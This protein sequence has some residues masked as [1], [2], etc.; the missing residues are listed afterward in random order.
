[1]LAAA[2]PLVGVA[3]LLWYGA[4]LAAWFERAATWQALVAIIVAGAVLCGLALLPTH[5]LSLA[6]GFVL[7]G[8]AGTLVAWATI[9]L[10]ALFGYAIARPL[11][12]GDAAN[13][14]RSSPRWSPFAD[15]LLDRS[16][17]RTVYLI[18]LVRL[19]PLVPF[20][21]TNTGLAALR[22]SIAPFLLGAAA[23]LLPR[24]AAVAWFGAGLATLDWQSPRSPWLLIVGG[25]A[26]VVAL[27]AVG[28][29]ATRTL[30]RAAPRS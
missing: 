11:T 20:A 2:L 21:A 28:R 24:I 30:R 18:A 26:T 14:L 9:V 29:V 6:A 1:M 5:A 22:V 8:I 12:G 4:E 10:A 23:G 13:R 3:F 27:V 19:S 17:L 25:V 7:G 15:A 16:R